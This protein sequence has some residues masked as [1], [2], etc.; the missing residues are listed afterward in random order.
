LGFLQLL[1][2]VYLKVVLVQQQMIGQLRCL[3]A[4]K[5]GAAQANVSMI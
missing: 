4:T 2:V 5:P 1:V 3:M